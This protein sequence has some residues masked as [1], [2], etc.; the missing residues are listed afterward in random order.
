[1]EVVPQTEPT[2]TKTAKRIA[3]SERSNLDDLLKLAREFDLQTVEGIL[4]KADAVWKADRKLDRKEVTRE[5]FDSFC[6]ELELPKGSQLRK[7]RKIGEMGK[8]FE[9]A[10][11]RRRLPVCWTTLYALAAI[12]TDGEFRKVVDSGKLSRHL[13]G[14]TVK[15]ILRGK[16]PKSAAVIN[17]DAVIDVGNMDDTKMR[18]LRRKLEALKEEFGFHMKLSDRFAQVVAT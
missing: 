5:Q 12:Q 17:R 7:W 15:E 14:E 11:I 18:Y 10:D 4:G 1:M 6:K 2:S 13:T 8:R 3:Q 16:K 9:P